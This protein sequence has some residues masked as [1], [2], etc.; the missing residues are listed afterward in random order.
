MS[1]RRTSHSSRSS[2]SRQSKSARPSSNSTSKTSITDKTRSSAY[3]KNFERY[4]INEK[5]FPEGYEYADSRRTPEPNYADELEE[6]LARSRPSLSPSRFTNEDFRRFK[7][8]NARVYEGSV[9]STVFPTIRGQRTEIPHELDAPFTGL[10]SITK[11]VITTAQPDFYDGANLANI[12]QKVLDELGPFIIPT[13]HARAPV[14]PNFFL[15]A[16]PPSGN[17]DVAKRQATLNGAVGARAMHKL[18]SYAAG[19]PVYDGNAYTITSTYHAGT[20]TLQMYTTH[21]TPPAGPEQPP[22]YH[23]NQHNSWGLT[24]NIATCRDGLK[25]FQNGRVY[26]KE[27]RN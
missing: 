15:E 23:M 2:Q 21:I 16:K 19:K 11:E 24:G 10:E 14:V 6:T 5:V 12:D 7:R 13:V 9:M 27:K 26:T 25:A 18:Q 4:I 1:S 17:V 20:G 3:D 22:E 8:D